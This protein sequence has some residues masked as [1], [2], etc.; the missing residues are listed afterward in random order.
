VASPQPPATQASLVNVQ[1]VAAPFQAVQAS[2]VQAVPTVQ[3][4]PVAAAPAP[5]QYVAVQSAQVP[6]VSATPQVQV[7]T[8][9]QLAVTPV[10]LLIPHRK[11]HLFSHLFGH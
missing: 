5:V 1:M 2:Y 4:V 11:C 8:Q 6:A 10:Q 9:N 3:Y 7:A